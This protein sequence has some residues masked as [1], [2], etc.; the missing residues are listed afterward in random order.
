[1]SNIK[2]DEIRLNGVSEEI[3]TVG[4]AIDHLKNMGVE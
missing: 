1:M 3:T 2:T 4:M